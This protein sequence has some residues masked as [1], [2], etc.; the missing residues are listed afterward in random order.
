MSRPDEAKRHDADAF[1]TI[2]DVIKAGYTLEPLGCLNPEC[3]DPRSGNVTHHQHVGRYGDACCAICGLWQIETFGDE[4]GQPVDLPGLWSV[5]VYFV[6]QCCGGPEEGGWY[7]EAG[8]RCDEPDLARLSWAKA[9]VYGDVAIARMQMVQ[10]ELDRDW[11]LGD[12]ARPLS[13]VLSAGRWESRAWPSWPP[14]R[15]QAETPRYE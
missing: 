5:A 12:H 9:D 6:E 13:S 11:N 3:P 2:H 14:P 10:A 15:F 8:D 1:F 4:H 7:F